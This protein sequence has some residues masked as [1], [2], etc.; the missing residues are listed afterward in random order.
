MRIAVHVFGG[1]QAT[2][3]S[4]GHIGAAVMPKLARR[5][6]MPLEYLSIALGVIAVALGFAPVV[7]L[8]LVGVA[9]GI[10]GI[11]ASRR[12][13]HADYRKDLPA[14]IGFVCSIAGVVVSA[15]TPLFALI[16][17]IVGAAV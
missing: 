4:E 1:L 3:S 11:V 8:Q 13:R 16:I 17:A 6:Y 14:T 2:V 12:A 9:L 5:S 7:P 15:V 10:C